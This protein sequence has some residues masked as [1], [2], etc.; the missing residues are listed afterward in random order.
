MGIQVVGPDIEYIDK[1]I[2]ALLNTKDKGPQH[3]A[4][5]LQ[6]FPNGKVGGKEHS[7]LVFLTAVRSQ[8]KPQA[9]ELGRKLVVN[10]HAD[11]ECYQA[12]VT[13]LVEDMKITLA[14]DIV[15]KAVRQYPDLRKTLYDILEKGGPS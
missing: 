3:E 7:I 10:G 5:L 9:I 2:R 15:A 11:A 1:A 6:R 12:L 8:H 14:E 13:L 4:K